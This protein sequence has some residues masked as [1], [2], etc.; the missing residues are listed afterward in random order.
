MPILETFYHTMF[1]S[2]RI[3]KVYFIHGWESSFGARWEHDLCEKLK[4]EK[5]YLS[6]ELSQKALQSGPKT[7]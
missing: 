2:G 3:R 6:P 7:V 5:I 4:I 1:S